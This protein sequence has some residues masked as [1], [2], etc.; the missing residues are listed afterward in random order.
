MDHSLLSKARKLIE[1]S[2][3]L[4]TINWPDAESTF[5]FGT[6][7]PRPLQPSEIEQLVHHGNT[8][9]DWSQVQAVEPLCPARVRNCTFRGWVILGCFRGLA[10]VGEGIKLPTGVYQ[11]TISDCCIGND[12]L[13]QE[14]RLLANCNVGP[15]AVLFDCGRVIAEGETAFGNGRDL[16]VGNETGGRSIPVFAELDVE[17]A[18]ALTMSHCDLELRDAIAELVADYK[19]RATQLHGYV[20]C[21]A[22]VSHTPFIR[23]TFIGEHAN[24][25]GATRIDDSTVLSSLEEPTSIESGALVKSSILQWGSRVSQFATVEHSILMEHSHVDCHGKVSSCILG[26]NTAI[27]KGEA[28]SCLLGPF[29]NMHHQSLLIA[30]LWPEGRGNISYGANVGSNHTGRAP[31]QEFRPGEGLF[32][33]LGA[34][35]K[36]PA[37]FSKAPYSII[38][39]GVTTLPQRIEFPFSL[40]NTPTGRPL[41]VPL[42]FGE[43]TPGWILSDS[44]YTLMRNE[45]KFRTRNKARR[46]V[47]EFKIL[48][49][50]IQE[51][52]AAALRRLETVEKTREFYL[53][54][55]IPGLGKNYLLEASRLSAIRAYRFFLLYA[56][57]ESLE[58]SLSE[59]LATGKTGSPGLPS[60]LSLSGP[61]RSSILSE[62]GIADIPGGLTRL[63]EMCKEIAIGVERSKARDDT[64]GERI[65]PGYAKAHVPAA[66]D[67]I[68]RTA[69]ESFRSRQQ[70]L[71]R[72]K[73]L[74]EQHGLMIVVPAR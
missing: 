57:L 63:E 14:V 40:I 51:L 67:P 6:K 15:G 50:E 43:I 34:S 74:L 39:A 19:R 64:R 27:A 41:E 4:R 18:A 70:H 3:L 49:P 13:I 55:D 21:G 61:G 46:S 47:P 37:D 10:D 29:V 48:R 66:E 1:H 9:A 28:T 45:T 11:S 24:I 31:D 16:S 42:A 54:E 12:S 65:M 26:P 7:G 2:E 22:R 30:T 53:D 60:L 23:N 44:L 69:W 35:I 72:L 71:S 59:L 38:A 36:F 68:V 32:V 17:I 33:G 62:H 58:G 8:C 56:A 73:S 20:C 5:A 25:C 52:M